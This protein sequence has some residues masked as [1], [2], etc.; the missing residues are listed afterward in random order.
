MWTLLA[1]SLLGSGPTSTATV[2]EPV[3]ATVRVHRYM[4]HSLKVSLAARDLT[5][6]PP[7]P[8]WP[9]W[10]IKPCRLLDADGVIDPTCF[11]TLDP[12][13]VCFAEATAYALDFHLATVEENQG[14]AQQRIDKGWHALEDFKR[15]ANRRHE[16]DIKAVA[17]L[18]WRD[19][20]VAGVAVGSLLV[21]GLIAG[22]TVHLTH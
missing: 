20:E 17:A 6:A 18:G 21:G 9:T 10:L 11:A 7:L 13:A 8:A 22:L 19:W 2:D 12:G 1:V 16:R 15:E 5:K 4:V 14:E 3:P